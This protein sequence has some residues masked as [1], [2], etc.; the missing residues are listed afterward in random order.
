MASRAPKTLL[1]AGR[2][3]RGSEAAWPLRQ[4]G[5]PIVGTRRGAGIEQVPGPHPAVG[6]L[7]HLARVRL[8]HDALT[9]A[10]PPHIHDALDI[11]RHLAQ[12]VVLVP[13]GLEVDVPLRSP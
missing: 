5:F 11:I 7:E 4:D 8:R 1:A 9:G 6:L 13:P 10:E 2:T 3:G 12:P